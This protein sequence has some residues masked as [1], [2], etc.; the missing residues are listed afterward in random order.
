MSIT[1]TKNISP[2]AARDIF[3]LQQ[4]INAFQNG[5]MPEDKFKAFRLTRGVYG[6]R[7]L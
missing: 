4:K 6:Q 2:E 7:Q 3:E 5:E 1:I